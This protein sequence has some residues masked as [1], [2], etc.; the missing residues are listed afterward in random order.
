[1]EEEGKGEADTIIMADWNSV[2]GGKSDQNIAGQHGMKRTI[3]GGQMLIGFC[4]R[5]RIVITNTWFE[6]PKRR[7][8]LWKALGN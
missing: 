5:K 7:L 1:L 3:Q 6:K 4:E 8:Y 2:V